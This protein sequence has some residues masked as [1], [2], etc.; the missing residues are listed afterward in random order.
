MQHRA[1]LRCLPLILTRGAACDSLSGTSR[2][3]LYF[4]DDGLEISCPSTALSPLSCSPP[5]KPV[6]EWMPA[7]IARHFG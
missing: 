4:G 1:L 5:I 6:M 3:S 7:E 2:T